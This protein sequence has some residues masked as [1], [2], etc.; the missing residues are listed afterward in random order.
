MDGRCAL[1]YVTQPPTDSADG[2][3]RN[4]KI[5]FTLTEIGHIDGE[6][7]LY[8]C[9]IINVPSQWWNR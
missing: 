4:R 6:E 9:G 3:Y 5:A 1:T 7:C 2:D 8:D